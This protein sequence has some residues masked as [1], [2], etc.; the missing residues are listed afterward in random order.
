[1]KCP[2]N[3]VFAVSEVQT[4][5]RHPGTGRRAAV[6]RIDFE[7]SS[8]VSI[9]SGKYVLVIVSERQTVPLGVKRAR[10]WIDAGASYICAW[11]PD[12][13]EVEEA[14]DYA[15]FLPQY[16]APLP[17]T[18]MTTSNRDK[19]PDEAL[20][21]AFYNAS[22]PDDLDSELNSV[23]IIVDSDSLEATCV[24]WVKENNE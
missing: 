12:S 17:F 13:A 4:S 9:A 14:F 23:V 10:A 2:T 18:L 5:L 21:F 1:V 7:N 16:G 19:T 11:G 15:S 3:D 24:A 6:V 22:P 8:P 20:W